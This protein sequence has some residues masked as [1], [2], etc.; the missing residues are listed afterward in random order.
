MSRRVRLSAKDRAATLE[1]LRSA[2]HL[3]DSAIRI[4]GTER[5]IG[6]DPI[7]GLLPVAGDV[8]T[9]AVSVYIVMEAVYLGAPRGTVLR[10]VF[11]LVVDATVGSIPIAGDLFDAFWKANERNVELLEARLE[12]PGGAGADL[13]FLLA[14]GAVMFAFLMG[15]T[16]AG[17]LVLGVL[18][19]SVG[20]MV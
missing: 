15:L 2:S 17:L 4:P 8:P 7:V 20:G 18:V 11:N 12:E 6:L 3:L 9:T 5:T 1:R 13:R 16:V 14:A 19:R 10:M